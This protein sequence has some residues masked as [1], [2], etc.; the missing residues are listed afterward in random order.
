MHKGYIKVL[1][2]HDSFEDG[3]EGAWAKKVGDAYML[4]NI[5][6]YAKEFSWGDIIS[7]KEIDGENYVD[8]L[9]KESGHSTVRVLFKSEDIVQRVRTELRALG[10]SS[11]MS[12]YNKLIS[13]DIPPEVKYY[14]V[15]HFLTSGESLDKWE[16]Q[17]ACISTQ[18]NLENKEE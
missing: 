13:V 3:L 15:R 10:C 8:E 4:D 2:T 18:H 12:N 7:I 16:Y 1:F 17:E 5:L 11:E 14:I 6:F 9:I